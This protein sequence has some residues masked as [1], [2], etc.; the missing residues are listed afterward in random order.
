MKNHQGHQVNVLS[1]EISSKYHH[2][3]IVVILVGPKANPNPNLK[4]FHALKEALPN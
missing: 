2:D 4:P 3:Y 1:V